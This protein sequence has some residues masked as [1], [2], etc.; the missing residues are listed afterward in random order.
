MTRIP[1]QNPAPG[2]NPVADT[3]RLRRG[4]HGLLPLDQVLLNAPEYAVSFTQW[5]EKV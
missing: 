5:R 4:A 3:I 1:Y 2:S